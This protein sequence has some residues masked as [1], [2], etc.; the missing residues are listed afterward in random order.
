[1]ALESI[2]RAPAG[3]HEGRC[4]ARHGRCYERNQQV[5]D[6]EHYLDVLETEASAGWLRCAAWPEG[7]MNAEGFDFAKCPKISAQADP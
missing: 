5:L 6:L 7:I 4:I 2:A 1:M 3:A